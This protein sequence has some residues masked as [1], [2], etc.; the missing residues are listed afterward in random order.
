MEFL[1]NIHIGWP[2]GIYL[3]LT[4]LGLA[5]ALNRHG[6]SKEGK[7]DAGTSFIATGIVLALLMWGGFFN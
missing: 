7:H 3:A 2:Q 1:L 4:L 5:V 6:K